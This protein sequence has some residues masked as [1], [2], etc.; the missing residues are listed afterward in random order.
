MTSLHAH[1]GDLHRPDGTHIN[2]AT[3]SIAQ[4]L[5]R[6]MRAH[7][8]QAQLPPEEKPAP[9]PV[10]RGAHA[11]HQH[12]WLCQTK[13]LVREKLGQAVFDLLRSKQISQPQ[14]AKEL[15]LSTSSL[16]DR[17]KGK[18]DFTLA[19]GLFIE[20]RFETDLMSLMEA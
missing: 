19:E 18:Q 5:R 8:L 15:G 17:L 14:F 2:P 16:N 4:R 7:E 12:E 11:E 1:D 9:K 6:H 20:W 13:Q 3:P 10:T